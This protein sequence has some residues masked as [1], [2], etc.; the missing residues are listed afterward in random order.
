MKDLQ[1]LTGQE[2]GI[3]IYN[4]KEAIIC[5]WSGIE[6]LPFYVLAMGII[7]LGEEIPEVEGQHVDDLSG[8]LPDGI[9][10]YDYNNI[11]EDDLP[12]GGK[13]YKIDEDVTVIAPDGW[14]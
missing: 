4:G 3:V 5:N 2:S 6:G 8:Y 14:A 10:V 11:D 7:G 9:I 12:K 1:E 13:V